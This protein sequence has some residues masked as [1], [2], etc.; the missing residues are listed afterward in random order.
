MVIHEHGWPNTACGLRSWLGFQN[1]QE[2][3]ASAA[4]AKGLTAFAYGKGV[5]ETKCVG[6]KMQISQDY[7]DNFSKDRK[8]PPCPFGEW[9]D[10]PVWDTF[11]STRSRSTDALRVPA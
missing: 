2:D 6:V 11:R 3:C 7:Y 5:A 9:K 10:N 8:A 1:S 4:R